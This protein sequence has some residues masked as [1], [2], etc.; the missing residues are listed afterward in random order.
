MAVK[1]SLACVD[2]R[3]M[4]IDPYCLVIMR[5]GEGENFLIKLFFALH[6]PEKFDNTPHR[7]CYVM[8][9]LLVCDIKCCSTTLYFA[10]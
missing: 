5:D 9:I 3:V 1:G 6:K 2:Y 8:S 4:A 10:C 7:Y